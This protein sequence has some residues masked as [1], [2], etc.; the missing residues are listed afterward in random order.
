MSEKYLKFPLVSLLLLIGTQI[1]ACKGNVSMQGDTGVSTIKWM[2]WKEA[3][4]E[5]KKV[6]K[7]IMI[8]LFTEWCG[9]CKRMDASTFVDPVIVEYVN[10]NFYAIKFD[11][12]QNEDIQFNDHTFKFVPNGRRGYHELAYALVDG[13]LS[14]PTLVY[15]TPKMERIMIS[16][17]FKPTENLLKELHFASDDIYLKT[18]WE[19]YQ[20]N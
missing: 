10:K 4:E 7:K 8:D 12:E 17:G 6:P 14:Y 15:L 20:K 2:S 19:D 13:Q 9:W 1:F 16:P 3:M 18:K 11:A 5:N